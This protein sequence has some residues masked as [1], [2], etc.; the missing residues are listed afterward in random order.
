MNP[1]SLENFVYNFVS[2]RPVA[3]S[4]TELKDIPSILFSI[5][6][7]QYMYQL[8]ILFLKFYD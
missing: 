5:S 2:I 8:S 1:N 7:T 6:F 3:S 4:T